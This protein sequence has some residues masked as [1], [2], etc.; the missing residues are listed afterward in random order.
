MDIPA[1]LKADGL[2]YFHHPSKIYTVISFRPNNQQTANRVLSQLNI[3][4]FGYGN[5]NKIILVKF[6][7]VVINLH[8]SK[9][10]LSQN[11]KRAIT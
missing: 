11:D 8:S 7:K 3:Y 4:F 10:Q 6:S 5:N 9:N 2:R 1:C